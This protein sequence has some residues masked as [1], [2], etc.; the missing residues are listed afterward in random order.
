MGE[1]DAA[2]ITGSQQTDATLKYFALKKK[3]DSRV[4]NVH[5]DD[6]YAKYLDGAFAEFS[7]VADKELIQKFL[8]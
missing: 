5:F 8:Q 7:V 2:A 4:K 6:F 1:A 3:K